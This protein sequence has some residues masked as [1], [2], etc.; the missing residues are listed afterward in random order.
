MAKEVGT[1]MREDAIKLF[2]KQ[3]IKQQWGDFLGK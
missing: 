1:K 2:G 3:K